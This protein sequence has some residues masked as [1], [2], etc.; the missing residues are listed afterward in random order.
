VKNSKLLSIFIVQLLCISATPCFSQQMSHGSMADSNSAPMDMKEMF[1][2]PFLAHQS[3]PDPVGEVSLRVTGYR[4][5][6]AG[7]DGAT[8]GDYAVHFET[9]LAKRL[10]L[11]IRADGIRYEE[12][13]DITL[14][15]ALV[16][17]K[18]S[19]KGVAIFGEL[20]VPTGNVKN[21]QYMGVFGVS[22]R[23]TASNFMV[24]DGN[25]EYGPKEKK[26]E[27]ENAFVFR[28]STKMYP[29]LE[30]RGSSDEEMTTAYLMP[31]IKFKV[32]DQTAIGVGFQAAILDHRDYNTQA[33][34]TWDFAF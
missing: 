6:L 18:T 22:A 5:R 25:I 32:N 34:L 29:I 13:S 11:H 33:L 26:T 24:W 2:H 27:F 1:V 3:L 15:Y 17:D 23:L 8:Q 12:F 16:A 14:Q 21:E 10:G 19:R 4:T 7:S 9:A 30:F 20:N 31:A 28:A